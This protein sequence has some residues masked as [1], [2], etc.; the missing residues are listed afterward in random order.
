MNYMANIDPNL[1]LYDQ[2]VGEGKPFADNEAFARS[3][4]EANMTIQEREEELARIRADLDTRMNYEE[5]LEHFKEKAPINAGNQTALTGQN[6]QTA[7]TPTLQDI[8]RIV[9][10]REQRKRMESNLDSAMLKYAEVNGPNHALK[11]KQQ[12]TELGMSEDQLKQMAAANPK[13]FFKL[14]GVEDV[15]KQDTFQAPPRTSVNSDALGTGNTQNKEAEKFREIYKRSPSEYWSP[16]V[17]NQLHKAVADGR[18]DPS[19]V[20]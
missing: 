17:Q 19:E 15:R 7:P 4:L 9:E 20:L 6:N 2:L 3:K 16:A 13:A 1:P 11:L 18:I 12:A 8:E 14:T 10:Q 5:F